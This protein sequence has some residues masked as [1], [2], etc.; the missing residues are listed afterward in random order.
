MSMLDLI[1]DPK[2]PTKV[3]I[4][5]ATTL[6]LSWA[7]N[8]ET[9]FENVMLRSLKRAL[10][11][12][13]SRFGALTAQGEPETPPGEPF[14]SVDD[15]AQVRT[16]WAVEV[17]QELLPLLGEVYVT[18]AQSTNLALGAVSTEIP[19]I[20][21]VGAQEWL[22]LAQNRLNRVGDGAW[23]N[24]RD[25]LLQGFQQGES[26]D[27]LAKR[28]RQVA[29]MSALRARTIARTEVLGAS[30]AG[31]FA[32]ARV[33]EVEFK[34]WLNT[35]D[36][37][38]RPTHVAAGEQRV[39]ID[40]PF[41]VGGSRLRFPHDP[42]GP[43]G[44]TINC[45]CTMLF[46]E[47]PLCVCTPA[48][49]Q[50][51]AGPLLSAGSPSCGCSDDAGIVLE[52]EALFTLASE[53]TPRFDRQL[54]DA[55]TD[56]KAVEYRNVNEKLRVTQGNITPERYRDNVDEDE[57]SLRG[58]LR[59]RQ[60]EN[61]KIAEENVT[62][63]DEAFKSV[64]PLGQKA[65]VYRGV[66]DVG[67]TF[68]GDPAGIEFTDYGYTSTSTSQL[69]AGDFVRGDDPGFVTILLP[70]D[71]RAMNVSTAT[72]RSAGERE[73]L[74]PRGSRF[75]ITNAVRDDDN[76]WQITMELLT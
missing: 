76:R 13:T 40:E 29:N 55:I 51:E 73:L 20:V 58:E 12:V 36:G 1:Q 60:L 9:A 11:P 63:I 46:D 14:V 70:E 35:H 4:E 6:H 61:I 38:T 64:K 24:M 75:R 44:E 31:S 50:K 49:V 16:T 42:L 39:S 47:D 74:L 30:N 34:T 71:T 10:R 33:M 28:V 15:L 59:P 2:P 8:L 7:I 27:A 23:L 21:S 45:R 37:R 69:A 52:D 17:A 5:A 18:G 68:G 48:W 25:E 19:D 22:G 3:S 66:G 26:I 67:A 65:Q 41:I 54:S 53:Q 57:L 32:E 56:Y 72:D 43:P 62:S